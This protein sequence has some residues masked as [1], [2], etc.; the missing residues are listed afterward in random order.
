[1]RLAFAAYLFAGI[2][3]LAAGFPAAL[4]SIAVI[5]YLIIVGRFWN[6]TDENCEDAN[7]SWKHFIKLNYLSG[8]LV[9]LL[10]IWYYLVAMAPAN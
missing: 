7:R 1:T 3:V 9:T 6:I 5:P 4:A 10:V 2:K 8:F